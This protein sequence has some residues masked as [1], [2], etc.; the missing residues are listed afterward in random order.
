ME[1]HIQSYI[2]GL[3]SIYR[4]IEQAAPNHSELTWSYCKNDRLLDTEQLMELLIKGVDL[5][6]IPLE[7]IRYSQGGNFK[8]LAVFEND[9]DGNNP[10]LLLA[11][12]EQITHSF[13]P[14]PN[15]LRQSY[16]MVSIAGFG[17]GDPELLTLKAQRLITEAEIILYDDL[18][19]DKYLEQ[20]EAELI[21]VGKRKGK[22]SI[23]QEDINKLLYASAKKGKKVLRLKGGDP[24]IF[25]RGAEE[26]QYLNDRYVNVTIV[27]GVT[28][29]LAAAADTAIPLTS[30]GTSTSVAFTLGH[31][32]IYNKLPKADTLVFYMGAAQQ[33]K[34]A[35]RLMKEGWPD[36]TPVACVRNASLATVETIPYTLDELLTS[37]KILPAPALLIVGQTAGKPVNRHKKWLYTGTDKR[38]FKKDGLLVHNPMVSIEAKSMD[39]KQVELFH[40]IRAFDRLVFASPFA[41]HHFFRALF[42]LEFDVRVLSGIELSSIGESTSKAL[43]D[44]GLRVKPESAGN[45]A[46]GLI[47]SMARNHVVNDTILLPCSDDGFNVLPNELRKLGNQVFEL[48]LYRSVIPENVV[49]HNLDD[50]YGVVFTSPRAV[51]HFFKLHLTLPL[52]LKISVRG[53]YTKE[54][55]DTYM[56]KLQLKNVSTVY[57]SHP[58][59]EG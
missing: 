52:D 48:N 29:A 11:L 10:L 16:G 41:V 33:Q 37:K 22:H 7:A 34:W 19:D 42:E 56:Q 36:D 9:K 1:I 50:F 58:E 14:F 51:H 35:Q 15:D 28:S 46:K 20:F 54:V 59:F 30:R 55:L 5:I 17:P 25:G 53:K 38:Y 8:P 32:A 26:Y 12:N 49:H 57:N 40:N 43:S 24:L 3:N 23:R 4:Q 2:P 13:K 18:L 47:R 21:Y 31:D 39:E 44:Y 6:L 27:P 45:S